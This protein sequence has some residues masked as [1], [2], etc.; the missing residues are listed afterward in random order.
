MNVSEVVKLFVDNGVT[1]AILAYFCV[2][3]WKFMNTL[4]EVLTTL[5]T[6]TA[7][8]VTIVEDHE[9]NVKNN[10]N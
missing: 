10:G 9:R 7:H 1:I 3:D 5:K 4:T 2:R 8:I 6:Q